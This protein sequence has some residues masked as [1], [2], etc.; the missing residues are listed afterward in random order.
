M[1]AERTISGSIRITPG[2]KIPE[3]R[4]MFYWGIEKALFD[5]HHHKDRSL[6]KPFHKNQI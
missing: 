4:C 6:E 3:R 5:A 2:E 1:K